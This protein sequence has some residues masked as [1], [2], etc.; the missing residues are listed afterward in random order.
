LVIGK[1]TQIG[2][3]LNLRI[4]PL[5]EDSEFY[6]DLAQYGD[7]MPELNKLK[8]LMVGKF[9]MI[10]SNKSVFDLKS[11]ILENRRKAFAKPGDISQC[12]VV[13]PPGPTGMDP[14]QISFFHAL[15]I[16][17]KINKG[18]IE[19]QKDVKVLVPGQKVGAS[20]ADLLAKMNIQ[21]FSYGME[22]RNVYDDGTILEKSIIDFDP[23][24]LIDIFQSGVAKINAISLE[25]GYVVKSAVPHMIMNA[26]KN[27]AAIAVETGYKLDAL[28]AA[29]SAG[30]QQ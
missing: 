12:E 5:P 10:F 2:V 19:I 3:A 30:A 14:S 26:F 11:I 20:E 21:P 8:A 15:Q 1:R 4:N 24:T 25:T 6:E 7:A 27:V 9:G 17:T 13:V 23:S 29:Q 28:E 22:I 16:T 18:M